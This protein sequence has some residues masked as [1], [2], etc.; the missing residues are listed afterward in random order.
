MSLFPRTHRRTGRPAAFSQSVLSPAFGSE[1]RDLMRAHDALFQSSRGVYPPVNLAETDDGFVLTAEVPGIEADALDVT[2]EGSTVTI[3][4]ARKAEHTAGD[5]T[6]VHRR[7][8]PTGHFRRAFELPSEIDVDAAKATHKDG[9]LKLTL[10][11]SP[12]L[13]ARQIE[14]E[15]R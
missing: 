7:E 10:P 4:G 6:S 2:I 15:T 3:A 12:A 8:R 1:L 5:G 11:K 14:V 13:R 9:V